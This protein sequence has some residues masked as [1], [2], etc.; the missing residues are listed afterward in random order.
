[1]SNYVIFYRKLDI[2]TNT[3]HSSHLIILSVGIGI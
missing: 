1:M 2:K 3:Y